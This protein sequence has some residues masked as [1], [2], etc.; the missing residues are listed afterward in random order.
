M[1]KLILLLIISLTSVQSF[2]QWTEFVWDTITFEEPYEYLVIDTSSQNIWQI[3]EPN[4][5][6]FDSA[7]SIANAIVT[8]TIDTYP[9]NNY[10]FFDLFLGSY[11][12]DWFPDDNFIEIKHKFDT[13][14]LKDG[15][16]ITVSY[17][18]GQSWMNIIN[19]T[20]YYFGE[21]PNQYNMFV[22]NLYSNTDTLFN[23]EFGFSG[24]SG[25]WITTKFSWYYW[26]VKTELGDTL[27]IRFNF[28]SDNIETNNEGWMIDNIRLYSMDLG[29]RVNEIK[30]LD[31][32]ISPNPINESAI[33]ELNSYNEVEVSVFNIQGQLL[34]QKNYLNNQPIVINRENFN[35]GIYFVKIRTDEDLI[36]IRKLIIR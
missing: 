12:I 19:D 7:Y 14:T 26:P 33:I 8:D 17:D 11:N 10:S 20:A 23:G 18:N 30:T 36:G 5:I 2:A 6:F 9:I 29:G 25:D 24:N 27:T 35:S 3:G 34:R 22:E 1:K 16:Y 31:F 13:D 21:T 32:S 4:K 15:G 28:I